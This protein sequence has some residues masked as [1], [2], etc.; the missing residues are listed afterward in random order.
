[1]AADYNV[2]AF[3]TFW[4]QW[5]E[6]IASQPF[7]LSALAWQGFSWVQS[8]SGTNPDG[9]PTAPWP[10]YTDT[11]N[12]RIA[13]NLPPGRTSPY[14]GAVG[15]ITGTIT[16][17]DP[18]AIVPRATLFTDGYEFGHVSLFDG[19]YEVRDVPVG[20]YTLGCQKV[21]F[22][23]ATQ[24]ITV[25]AGQ[26]I[27]ANFSLL[28]TGRISRGFYFVDTFAGHSGC[29]GCQLSAT[30]HAQSFT[31]PSDVGFIKY[32]AC[33]PNVDNL[34]IRFTIR[35]GGPNG[36][37]IGQPMTATL[38]PGVGGNMIGNEWP[39][40]QEPVVQPNTTYFLRWE[41][42]DGQP[43]YC[44]ASNSNPYSGGNAYP[45]GTSQASI[46][47]YAL[48]RG[49]TPAV[50]TAVGTFSGTVKDTS[51]NPISGATVSTTPATATV[52]TNGSG[53]YTI[54]NVP[55]GTYN[56]TASQVGYTAQTQTNKT[57]TSG[58]TTTVN[59]NLASGPTTGTISGIIR[60]TS[61]NPLSGALVETTT[62]GYSTTTAANGTYTLA[63][64]NPATYTVRASKT[65]YVTN[66]VGGINVLAGQITTANVNLA[67]IA[68]FSG[69]ANGNFEGGFYNNPDGDHQSGNSWHRFSLAGSSKSG[70][71][72]GTYH[73]ANWSQTIYESSWTAGIYQQAANA[74]IGNAYQG[75]V[76]VRGSDASLNFW[77]GVDPAGGTD[78][79][80]ASIVWSNMATPGA[81]WVQISAQAT[82]T[83]STVT[84]FIKA[85]NTVASNRNAFID[86][87][88]LVDLGPTSSGTISGTVRDT[89]S[90]PLSGATVST[91]MG[92]YTT[93]SAANGTYTLAG[94]ATGTYDVVS[95]KSGY[96]SQ[97]QSA[98]QVLAD[99]TTTV[100]FNLSVASSTGTLGGVVRDTNNAVLSGALVTTNTGGYSATS[101]A[102]GNYTI[103]NVAVGTYNVTA[104]KSG[105]GSV[106]QTGKT[107]AAGQTTTVNFNLKRVVAE[108]FNSV[109]SWTSTFDAG[110]GGVATWSSVSGGQAGNCLQATRANTGSSS[111]VKVYDVTPNTSYTIKVYMR[112]PS[113]TASYWRECYYKLG[114]NT[115]QN[116]DSSPG[117]WTEIKKFSNTGTNGNGE[118]WVQ[119]TKTF[120]SGGN[121]QVSVGFKTGNSSGTAPTI[122]WDTL[123][124]E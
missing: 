35:Q 37:Q 120:N 60:D 62:G 124:I 39:D 54:S 56:I 33:K 42:T 16:R 104:S 90:N 12:L 5:P 96:V 69:I 19:V 21:G 41:R 78:A 53:V 67:P 102:G 68:P 73:S 85:Q 48:I 24:Q 25:T 109:P 79:N 65:G 59:F 58:Q 101:D 115:A 91:T 8:S 15:N 81:N 3:G 44:Y 34:T 88:A 20:T 61:N 63:N 7:L 6:I 86:D 36:T 47:F 29:S 82:A 32:A 97:T 122:K 49:L 108:D 114:S 116:F 9:T 103:N 117:T 83:T 80:A 118:A 89:S 45:G 99:Q 40:G 14:T 98:V 110:W 30:Y 107:V 55:V 71:V 70:G 66:Q 38:E 43:V 26:T 123:R 94:V 51:N 119:Y 95:S 17:S 112:C 2:S 92:G 77:V 13:L 22:Q 74:T 27:T 64:V 111:K 50:S 31:T 75:S 100:N 4:Y 121:T 113:S 72:Y 46:D 11:R 76:W 106:T 18:G 84:L 105:Y 28:H 23:T 93:T 57:I 52:T 1:M 87:A 10:Q